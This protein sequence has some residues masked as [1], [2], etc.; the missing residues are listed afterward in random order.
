MDSNPTHSLNCD[1]KL[2]SGNLGSCPF[3]LEMSLR[4]RETV[5]VFSHLCNQEIFSISSCDF[6]PNYFIYFDW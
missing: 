1:I 5:S 2:L 6:L 4:I 3:P